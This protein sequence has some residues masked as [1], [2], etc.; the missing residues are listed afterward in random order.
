MRQVQ[1]GNAIKNDEWIDIED[2][3]SDPTT[4]PEM[5]GF[6]VLVRPASIKNKTKGGIFIPD[7]TKDDMSYLTTVGRVIALGDLAY[8][9]LDKFPNG[10]W[11]GVGDYVCYG[12]HAGTK[13][14]YQNV[15]LL[16]LFDDQ[17]IMRVSDP[18]D[19]DPTFN[20][21]KH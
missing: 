16:L 6:H 3:V 20:L 10:D 14:Y 18:K 13:L 5:P 9:D 17:V 8:K 19:L 12:K 1:M 2:E 15:K 7:S 11:C 4:L 21:S